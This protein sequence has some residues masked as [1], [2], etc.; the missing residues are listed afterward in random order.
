MRLVVA[1][2]PTSAPRS[3]AS[4]RVPGSCPTPRGRFAA[5]AASA[6]VA[7]MNAPLTTAAE[8]LP[9]R[10]FTVKE[11]ERMVEVGLIAEDERIELIGGEI[12][13]MSPKGNHHEV[14]KVALLHSWY[15]TVPAD[16]QLA[17]ETTFRLA[18]DTYLEPDIVVYRRADGLKRLD[19]GTALLCVE[20]ADKSLGY[21]LHRKPAIYAAFGV[22]EL[23]V[24]DAVRRVTHV[25]RRPGRGGYGSVT[26]HAGGETLVPLL[27]PALPLRIDDLDLSDL[28][29]SA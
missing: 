11:V 3:P 1:A 8:G 28:D 12:V 10:A 2:A 7:A 19:G 13:P 4:G 22:A 9:R 17:P 29:S 24:I 26:L 6:I 14:L 27:A 25:H 15:R 21:D 20:I 18:K 23:W 16:L 5:P